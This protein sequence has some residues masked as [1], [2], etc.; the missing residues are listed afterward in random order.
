MGGEALLGGYLYFVKNGC[1]LKEI[2]VWLGHSDISTTG[3]I[4]SHLDVE[5][6]QNASSKISSLPMSRGAS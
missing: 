1:N 2:Q 3:N 5:D 6:M 4:Y